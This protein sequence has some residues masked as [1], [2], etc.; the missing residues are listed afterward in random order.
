MSL[1]ATSTR[2]MAVPTEQLCGYM[3]PEEEGSA[4]MVASLGRAPVPSLEGLPP[5]CVLIRTISTS[6]C[7]SDLSGMPCAD[8]EVGEWRGF[9]DEMP[10]GGFIGND[11]ANDPFPKAG[12]PRPGG[13][14]HELMGEV[15]DVVE[16]SKL[17][18]GQRVLAMG[19][20]WV[21]GIAKTDFEAR[22]GESVRCLAD[23]AQGGGFLEYFVST[24]DAT[25]PVPHAVPRPGFDPLWYVAAQPFGTILKAASKLGGVLGKSVVIFGQGQVSAAAAISPLSHPNAAVLLRRTAS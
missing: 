3:Q 13:S 4:R 25:I 21:M 19:T 18:I 14:G 17:S 8:C 11:P 6:I 9:T 15:A 12:P 10:R 7:G 22:T 16:P 5:G 2:K 23:K 1:P 20:G 24:E